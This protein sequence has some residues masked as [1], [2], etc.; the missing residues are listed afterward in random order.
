MS[1]GTREDP[2]QKY[3]YIQHRR[4]ML[5]E[6]DIGLVHPDHDAP[7][8]GIA[9]S[10]GGIRSATI[11]LGVVQALAR[12]DRFYGFDFMSSSSG[13]GYFACFLRSLF[14]PDRE[15]EPLSAGPVRGHRTTAT[16]AEKRDTRIARCFN[17]EARA[18]DLEEAAHASLE[19]ARA[20]Y[21][22]RRSLQ[23]AA[24]GLWLRTKR[25]AL[26]LWSGRSKSEEDEPEA[27]GQAQT[28]ES[29]KTDEL[30]F[31]ELCDNAESM[32]AQVV[33]AADQAERAALDAAIDGKSASLGNA[34][35]EHKETQRA[36]GRLMAAVDAAELAHQDT[37]L[38][39]R[40]HR[41]KFAN[42]V[43]TSAP[44]DRAVPANGLVEGPLAPEF[45]R[46]P[47]YWL[48]EH[49][50][51]LAPG[52]A[53]DWLSGLSY[54]A[55]NWLTLMLAIGLAFASIQFLIQMALYGVDQSMEQQLSGW[56]KLEWGG[57]DLQISQIALFAGLFAFL[58]LSVAAAYFIAHKIPYNPLSG[59]STN[60]R[61][62]LALFRSV[63]ATLAILFGGFLAA[64]ISLDFP[65]TGLDLAQTIVGSQDLGLLLFGPLWLALAAGCVFLVWGAWRIGYLKDAA[66]MAQ[67]LRRWL[68]VTQS[69]FNL[70]FLVLAYLAIVDT[71]AMYLHADI[72]LQGSNVSG[73]TE[74]TL[75]SGIMVVILQP[76]GA[77][78]IKKI[79]EM[80]GGSQNA[81]VGFFRKSVSLTSLV[82]G[83]FLFS[84]SAI[85]AALLVHLAIW[86][87]GPWGPLDYSNAAVFGLAVIGTTAVLGMSGS[88]A[89]MLSLHT[90]YAARLT[91][92]YLG[93]TNVQRLD[94]NQDRSDQLD[95]RHDHIDAYSYFRAS[96]P[97]PFHLL[98]V[99][100]NDTVSD[101]SLV[102]RDR[103]SRRAT[104]EHDGLTIQGA[105]NSWAKE[106]ND[107]E[108]LTAGQ[109]CAI[110]GAAASSGMGRR[111]TMG[112]ALAMSFANV[113]LGYWWDRGHKPLNIQTKDGSAEGDPDCY[114]KANL[115]E[116]PLTRWLPTYGNL[117]NEMRAR[118]PLNE[119]RIYLSD[120][121][122]SENTG[123]M[124]LLDK[125]CATLLVC[126][127]GADPNYEFADLETFIRTARI[128]EN[129]EVRE[130][131]VEETV[132]FCGRY[133]SRTHRCF[134]NMQSNWRETVAQPGGNAFALLLKAKKITKRASDKNVHRPEQASIVWLIPRMFDQ[135]PADII[136]YKR[137]EPDFPNH[138]TSDQFFDE[139]QWESYRRIGYE[140][141]KQLL[142]DK[143]A[144]DAFPIVRSKA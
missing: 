141:V 92:A 96:L 104:F 140:M 101:S 78:L 45:L 14:L 143:T 73:A 93:A 107:A 23:K 74:A 108:R 63:L 46:H 27:A 128:D 30:S 71:I 139:A 89:N 41:F 135:L 57:A 69:N 121:G 38:I 90:F 131:T 118:F 21:A 111:T 33:L 95:R 31:D 55:R 124:A 75:V 67:R 43:L 86:K 79:P 76:I 52:G 70:Y 22:E 1:N 65:S 13:G 80:Y 117:L 119:R 109:L 106:L 81:I 35:A 37:K 58:S 102:A 134:L 113:R 99:T 36:I 48:R 91:R 34:A 40:S 66:N 85:T 32:F 8:V 120:A 115:D 133:R 54:V 56:M 10:G 136:A 26:T 9:F 44:G 15:R 50:R 129:Y 116:K 127:N 11:S 62:D 16:H 17:M 60:Q 68:L 125:G 144:L 88:L 72:R 82:A 114:I 84:V 132:E 4:K 19:K 130:A 5:G 77:F 42:E 105:S 83:A 142:L 122:H 137:A 6:D 29:D 87:V 18:N 112:G 12:R 94:W 53:A 51:Y 20:R 98:N 126:D 3:P 100:I 39:P 24:Y 25:A 123:A 28:P 47:I 61:I 138:K 110:S 2:L 7:P 97:A 59:H 49:G 64:A 103:K